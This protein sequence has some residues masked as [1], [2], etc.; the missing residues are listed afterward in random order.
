MNRFG[1]LTLL[2]AQ[3][4]DKRGN[5]RYQC[6]CDCGTIV[7]VL[8]RDLHNGHTRSCGCLSREATAQRRIKHGHASGKKTSHEYY[9]WK[10]MRY[11]CTN[12]RNPAYTNY[13]GRGIFVCERW[14]SFLNFIADMGLQPA[15]LTLDR[16]DNDG[17]YAPD[18]CRW[19]T[20]KE[21]AANRRTRRRKAPCA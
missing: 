2:S 8:R 11:R 1:R 16:I 13:G 10:A 21:Q 18:N 4:R 17:P 7:T 5:V 9:I 12:P 20:R 6:R 15:G 19:A 3:S 14:Q